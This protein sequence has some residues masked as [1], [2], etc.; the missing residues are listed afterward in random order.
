MSVLGARVIVTKGVGEGGKEVRGLFGWE[1]GISV[2]TECL[3][4]GEFGG[5]L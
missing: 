1:L 5:L 2:K 4:V 3:Q